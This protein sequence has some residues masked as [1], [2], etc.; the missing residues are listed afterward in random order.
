[1]LA[2][3][4]RNALS[5]ST[6]QVFRFR[7]C[8]RAKQEALTHSTRSAT[9]VS[10]PIRATRDDLDIIADFDA[11]HDARR[12]SGLSHTGLFGHDFL[13]TPTS[14]IELANST[15]TRAQLLT[16]RIV[17]AKDTREELF[18]VVKHLDRLSDLLCGVID[19]AECIRNSHPDHAW[20]EAAEHVYLSV[21]EFMNVLNTNRD[22][23]DVRLLSPFIY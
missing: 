19:L 23:C 20:L 1:M 18:K 7:G 14:F 13:T 8:L 16:R 3:T 5:K 9:T 2:R 11:P 17:K 21:H 4:A 15:I 10:A 22:L 12:F 6:R